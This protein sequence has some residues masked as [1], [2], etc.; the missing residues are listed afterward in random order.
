MIEPASI[1]SE[2][3]AQLIALL[4]KSKHGYD[5]WRTEMARLE[6]NHG[7]HVYRDLFFVLTHLDFPP[8]KAKAHWLAMLKTWQQLNQGLAKEVDLRVATLHH[9]LQVPR[10]LKNPTMVEIK[11]FQKTQ[12]SVILDELTQLY[13]YRY[14]MDRLEHE[15]KRITRYN[16]GFSL[17][18]IDIDD[19]KIFNDRNGHL[20][21]NNALKKVAQAFRKCVR[22]VDVVARYG[23]EEF[24]VILPATLKKGALTV[25]EKIRARVEKSQIPGEES[26]PGGKLTVSIGVATI[27]A[28]AATTQDLIERAD[29]ALYRA[30]SRGKNRV[31]PYSEERRGFARFDASLVGN[32]RV[33]DDSMLPIRTANISEGGVLFGSEKPFTPGNMVQLELTL[34]G[35]G[36][37]GCTARVVR[38]L[39]RDG[40]GSRYEVGVMI[41][42]V[43]GAHRHRFRKYLHDLAAAEPVEI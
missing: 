38:A 2:L 42:H 22:D 14:F 18:M 26:Q 35:S 37:V 19:F 20:L 12:D 30:K 24:A 15:V 39:E 1:S 17:I 23:G 6:E 27:P 29:A 28:D 21:G 9:F 31:L 33:L 5:A 10:K 25:A 4:E 13:N 34:P 8:A 7:T 43:E 40:G 3:S 16:L 36:K 41:V 32:L 11:I